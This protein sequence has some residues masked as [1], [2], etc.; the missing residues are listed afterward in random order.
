MTEIAPT[1]SVIIPTYNRAH[2]VG[3]AIR[4][5]LNQTYQDFEIIVVDDGST[6]NTGEVVKGL[7][8]PR[9]HYIR[10]EQN[11]GGSAARNTGIRASR[12]EYIAFLDSDDEWRLEKLKKQMEVFRA[13][14]DKVGAVYTGLQHVVNGKCA[15]VTRPTRSGCIRKE[16]LK[17]NVVGT[18]SSVVARRKCFLLTGLFDEKMPAAQD[19]DM[20]V[21]ISEHYYF[22]VI[23][24]PLVKVH[25]DGADRITKN[26]AAKQIAWERFN[27]KYKYG[28]PAYQY[29]MRKARHL[30][31]VGYRWFL[32]GEKGKARRL[33]WQSLVEWPLSLKAWAYFLITF[34][35]AK[36]YKKA[37]SAIGRSLGNE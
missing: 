16:L 1:V 33:I 19:F 24:D 13:A 34:I 25:T 37:R 17:K 32:K 2:L 26:I 12:G 10:Y 3:R 6:D 22:Q 5:V 11:R 23:S 31:V 29:R 15:K 14:S 35:G 27:Q 18:T 20:W 30:A 4:S 8:D 36:N 28:L 7:N 21:R 9:I